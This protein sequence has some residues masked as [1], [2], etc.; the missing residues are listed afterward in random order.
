REIFES[1]LIILL[2]NLGPA[3]EMVDAL[4]KNRARLDAAFAPACALRKF[5]EAGI[6]TYVLF[7]QA[8]S[9]AATLESRW[10]NDLDSAVFEVLPQLYVAI[11][12]TSAIMRTTNAIQTEFC[13]D[14]DDP[15]KGKK[16][17]PIESCY[18]PGAHDDIIDLIDTFL[19]GNNRS[20]EELAE[21]RK[22]RIEKINSE[23]EQK[24]VPLF[25]NNTPTAS[26]TTSKNSTQ[27]P[28]VVALSKN[29]SI[30]MLPVSAG[31]FKMGSP[32]TEAE[33]SSNEEQHSVTISQ[34]FWL[35]KTQVT[36]AQW[37]AIMGN[38][39]SSFK[40]A[41]RPVENVSWEDAIAFCEKLTKRERAEKRL[42][43]DLEY[44]LPTEAEWEYACRAGSTGEYAGTGKLE[45]MGWFGDNSGGETHDV[46]KKQPNAWGF[47]DM[48]GNVWEW[49]ADTY[50]DYPSGAVTDPRGAKTG[51]IRVFRGGSWFGDARF[52]RSAYRGRYEPGYRGHDLGFRL[53]LKSVRS[54]ASPS[55][56]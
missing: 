10:K 24:K 23:T 26:A 22:R 18:T 12:G 49:C 17:Y 42:T 16:R 1:D 40:G 31:S 34:P 37:E 27:K 48:H 13:D 41:N 30:E 55:S 54:P 39:P 14:K 25:A 38:N 4:G 52:C 50:G 2:F 33:R 7:S 21:A 20:E 3:I 15:Q 6:A 47:Y 56:Q 8:D 46:A 28:R 32:E 35:G 29:I 45:D 36:Q 9:Y 19:T 43:A 44:A 51:V 5:K 53:A 11:R